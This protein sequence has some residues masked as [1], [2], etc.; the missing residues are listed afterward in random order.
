MDSGHCLQSSHR[1]HRTHGLSSRT[2]AAGAE[3]ATGR[4]EPPVTTPRTTS[5]H[6][7]APASGVGG[8]LHRSQPRSRLPTP[9]AAELTRIA[10]PGLRSRDHVWETCGVPRGCGPLQQVP[11]G[12]PEVNSG[13]SRQPRVLRPRQRNRLG[14]K[15]APRRRPSPSELGAGR[16]PALPGRLRTRGFRGSPAAASDPQSETSDNTCLPHFI[17]EHELAGN[18]NPGQLDSPSENFK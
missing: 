17:S 7:Y 15:R 6:A 2:L 4:R 18:L 1:P 12:R 8:A 5:D 16:V 9:T 11:P 13:E 14:A 10:R 3:V